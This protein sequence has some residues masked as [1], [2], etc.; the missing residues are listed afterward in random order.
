MKSVTD[1][2]NK[3]L[4]GS[5]PNYHLPTKAVEITPQA[6]EVMDKLFQRLT[7][8]FPAWRSALPTETSIAEFK[9]FWLEELINA[10]IR[11]W[12]LLARGLERCKQSKS[13]FLP[14]IGQF[15]EWCLAEDYQALGLPDEDKLYR[16]LHAFMRFGIEEIGQ[17]KFESNA[18]YWLIT[19]LYVRCRAGEWSEKT[20]RSEIG[21][22]LDKMAGRLKRCEPIPEPKIT[23]PEQVR[24]IDKDKVSAF[25]GG[26][27]K[28]LGG[29]QK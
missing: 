13:P 14:S 2:S 6:H 21:K 9:A 23:L 8:I 24:V 7:L 26:L 20:L 27:L 1:L 17:F 5:E 11:N 29:K 16:R 15:I 19:D 28:Q 3:P 18:E 25:F 22:A 10:K 4:V 12:K